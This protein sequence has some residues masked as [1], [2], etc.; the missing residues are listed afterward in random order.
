LRIYFKDFYLFQGR[1]LLGVN[2]ELLKKAEKYRQEN[3]ALRARFGI[4]VDE[5][6]HVSNPDEFDLFQQH[7]DLERI[8]QEI[9]D[10]NLNLSNSYEEEDETADGVPDGVLSPDESSGKIWLFFKL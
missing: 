4:S 9:N 2:Q 10:E 6:L 1:E 3:L 7:Q 5:D 8:K